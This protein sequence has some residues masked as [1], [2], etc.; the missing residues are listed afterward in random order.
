[1]F[2]LTNVVIERGDEDGVILTD[3]E[4]DRCYVYYSEIPELIRRLKG[5]VK[6]D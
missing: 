2:P 5:Y 1:M 6:E 4:G 3:G